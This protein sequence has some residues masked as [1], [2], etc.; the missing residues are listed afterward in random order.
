MNF[1]LTLSLAGSC[2]M[3][4]SILVAKVG[5]GYFTKRWEFMMMKIAMIFFLVP[6]SFLKEGYIILFKHGGAISTLLNETPITSFDYKNVIIENSTKVV[7]NF[8]LLINGIICFLWITL[9]VILFVKNLS[10]Y[11][12]FRKNTISISTPVKDHKK[13]LM[14]DK[15]RKEYGIKRK[16]QIYSTEVPVSTF[17]IGVWNPIII[18]NQEHLDS[19]FELAMRHEL[20]HIKNWDTAFRFLQI[21]VESVH[22]FNP[23]IYIIK[24]RLYTICEYAC[25]EGTIQKLTK[26]KRVSYAKLLVNSTCG[27]S[28][29]QPWAATLSS[30]GKI[31][32]ERVTIIMTNRKTTKVYAVISALVLCIMVLA[33]SMTVLAYDDINKVETTN[34]DTKEDTTVFQKANLQFSSNETEE[35][36]EYPVMYER[37]F[38]NVD[39][40][41]YPMSENEG[42]S[43]YWPHTH[44]YETG[45]MQAHLKNNTGG[46]VTIGYNA[47]RCIYCGDAIIYDEVWRT[48]YQKCTH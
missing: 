1:V 15:L 38:I 35:M 23:I 4:L 12:R 6:M 2:M 30:D 29:A 18:V 22:W 44:V 31:I 16:I 9:A 41:I 32:G 47:E 17:T 21:L 27:K 33:N 36:M 39:G 19:P 34:M 13:L 43:L 14:L 40:E 5:R 8:I 3:V 7:P 42:I 37:Q 11:F 26:E 10:Q 20:T 48:I 24:N 45:I 25:D 28:V 46:C